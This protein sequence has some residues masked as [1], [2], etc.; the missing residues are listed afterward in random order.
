MIRSS[1]QLCN[2]QIQSR[3]WASLEIKKLTKIEQFN[4]LQ[5]GDAIIVRWWGNWVTHHQGTNKIMLYNIYENKHRCHE[6]ICRLH[7]NHYFNYVS[8]LKGVSAAEEVYLI[9]E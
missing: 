4:S 6:I 5:K 3:K 8:Y 7:G 2:R 9:T 1:T